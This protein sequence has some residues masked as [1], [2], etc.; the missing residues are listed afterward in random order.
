MTIFIHFFCLCP[1][2]LTIKL[3]FNISK[4]ACYLSCL[5]T[6]KIF[7]S[8][9]SKPRGKENGMGIKCSL[10]LTAVNINHM[11]RYFSTLFMNTVLF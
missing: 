11:Y 7:S 6:L 2:C 9:S 3:N 8:N 4:V 1:L 10:R 5:W